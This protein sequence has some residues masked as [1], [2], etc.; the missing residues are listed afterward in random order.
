MRSILSL[1]LVFALA[2]TV[3]ILVAIQFEERDLIAKHPEYAAY[4]Q[5]GPMIVPGMPRRVT[6]SPSARTAEVANTNLSGF[7]RT[8]IASCGAN[9]G[10]NIADVKMIRSVSRS[11]EKW[12]NADRAR[13]DGFQSKY[14]RIPPA[15]TRQDETLACAKTCHPS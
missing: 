1:P 3:Y 9:T 8:V 5:Q 13:D 7:V 10:R 11:F 12:T 14:S 2:M 6:I 15:A 4:R